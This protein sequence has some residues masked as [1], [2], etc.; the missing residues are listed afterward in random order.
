MSVKIET[1]NDMNWQKNNRNAWN[2]CF[3]QKRRGNGGGHGKIIEKCSTARFGSP[4]AER[5][6][7]S[8]RDVRPLVAVHARFAKWRDVW[9]SGSH[10]S[11]AVRRCGQRKPESGLYLYQG[12]WK[13]QRRGK[14]VDK[15]VGRTTG[16]LNTKLHVI[17]DG[18]GNPVEF[19]LSAGNDHDSIHA[20]ELL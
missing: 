1:W 9:Y 13:C 6:G 16:G 4:A 15:A 10:I 17:V 2:R 11:C 19:M 14:T 18:L 8:C 3:R 12:P 20:I 7:R 5:S